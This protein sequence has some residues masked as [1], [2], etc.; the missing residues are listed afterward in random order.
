M[1]CPTV[2][3]GDG[4]G[5]RGV[6]PASSSSHLPK[7]P[8]SKEETLTRMEQ[9]T[10][11]VQASRSTQQPLPQPPYSTADKVR[12]VEEGLNEKFIVRVIETKYAGDDG[13]IGYMPQGATTATYWTT[14][15]TQLEHADKDAELITQSVGIDY[16]PDAEYTLPFGNPPSASV[17][18]NLCSNVSKYHS[19]PRFGNSIW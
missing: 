16:N 9:A 4:R 7:P 10:K 14:T 6:A 18:K 3:I 12:V 2:L 11:K 15:Y 13:T 17:L 5:A 19:K 1:G 8:Q